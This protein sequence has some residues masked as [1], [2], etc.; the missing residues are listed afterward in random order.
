MLRPGSAGSS[1]SIGQEIDLLLKYP[2][3]RHL[4][5]LLGYSHFFAG[6]FI[7]ESGSDKDTDFLYVQLEYTF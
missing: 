1:R 3:D 2:F 6:N 7:Q 4:T 5:G